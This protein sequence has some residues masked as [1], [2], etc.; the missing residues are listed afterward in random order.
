MACIDCA[1]CY[2]TAQSATLTFPY[3]LI[4]TTVTIIPLVSGLPGGGDTTT[5]FST[6][7]QN[8]VGTDTQAKTAV[9]G[10]PSTAAIDQQ[11]TYTGAIT[12]ATDGVILCDS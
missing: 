7:T 6:V 12:W 3:E 9:S 2:L 11:F 5:G 1:P 8:I 4:A 10:Y